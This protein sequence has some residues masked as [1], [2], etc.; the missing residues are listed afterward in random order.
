MFAARRDVSETLQHAYLGAIYC[1]VRRIRPRQEDQEKGKEK[2]FQH[3]VWPPAAGRYWVGTSSHCL[4]LASPPPRLQMDMAHHRPFFGRSSTSRTSLTSVGQMPVIDEDEEVRISAGT[5]P[6]PLQAA[7]RSYRRSMARGLPPPY[8]PAAQLPP[9]YRPPYLE[10][11][12]R[13][14]AADL[15]AGGKKE[16]TAVRAKSRLRKHVSSKDDSSSPRR[17][18][19]WR[20]IVLLAVVM[21]IVVGLAVGL[22][23]GLKDKNHPPDTAESDEMRFPAGSFSFNTTLQKTTTSCTSNPSTWRC[24]PYEEGSSATFFWIISSTN[25]HAFTISSTENPFAP[26]FDNLAMRLVDGNQPTERFVFSFTMDKTVVPSDAITPGNRAAR[27]TF[28]ETEFEATLWTR[29]SG[30][31]TVSPPQRSADSRF[32]RWPGDV[33]VSQIKR[34]KQGSPE[35]EDSRGNFI[36]DVQAGAGQ[37]ECRYSTFEPA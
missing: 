7:Q 29:R 6:S 33:E 32:I 2:W 30:G 28:D 36:A 5:L 8:V 9:V 14:K 21:A 11:L 3:L 16:V 12:E 25:S 27:C 15:E 10:A 26:S 23:L 13:K 22:T 35:C 31:A 19:S 20:F 1:V 17:W 18:R 34:P 24:Y 4:L 37:C